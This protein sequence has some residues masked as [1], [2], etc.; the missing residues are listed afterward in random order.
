MACTKYDPLIFL[1]LAALGKSDSNVVN[2][3]K[4]ELERAA[5]PCGV[6]RLFKCIAYLYLSLDV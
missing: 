4:R 2:V 5:L 6:I 3:E 1:S